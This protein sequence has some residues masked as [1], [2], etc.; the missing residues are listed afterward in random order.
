[1]A[2]GEGRSWTSNDVNLM[3]LRARIVINEGQL[4][5]RCMNIRFLFLEIIH[6][7]LFMQETQM[8]YDP[9]D[10]EVVVYAYLNSPLFYSLK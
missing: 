8:M 5:R 3:R 9:R 10:E 6:E 4:D 1:M 7:R 2:R